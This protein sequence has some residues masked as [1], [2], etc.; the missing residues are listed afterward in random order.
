MWILFCA[1]VEARVKTYQPC[2]RTGKAW[3]DHEASS[4]LKCH[5][6]SRTWRKRSPAPSIPLSK[7]FSLWLKAI[8]MPFLIPWGWSLFF[9]TALA[10]PKYVG[11]DCI[12]W[13]GKLRPGEKNN[14]WI[15]IATK[16]GF[17]LSLILTKIGGLTS[18]VN[19][20]RVP[21]FLPLLGHCPGGHHLNV[22]LV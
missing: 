18:F 19:T 13:T 21:C 6:F 8:E 14:S 3:Q 12:G 4:S 1:E 7:T 5:E 22:L 15:E 10:S 2:W 9:W 17:F 16:S 20:G 11:Q